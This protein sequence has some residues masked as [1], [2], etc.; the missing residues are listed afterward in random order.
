MT[1]NLYRFN[2]AILST[3]EEVAGTIARALDDGCCDIVLIHDGEE[4]IT[5][6]R[7]HH[8]DLIII[9]VTDYSKSDATLYNLV[10]WLHLTGIDI[11]VI[12]SHHSV[13]HTMHLLATGVRQ[14]LTLPLPLERLRRKVFDHLAA[15]QRHRASIS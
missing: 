12:T 1:S 4:L 2:V 11:F 5:T 6:L 15:K 8:L 10:K 13:R 14:C 9:V 3:S 7:R